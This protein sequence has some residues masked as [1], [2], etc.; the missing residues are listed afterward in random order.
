MAMSEAAIEAA[1]TE[2][3]IDGTIKT[4]G[5][6]SVDADADAS[7]SPPVPATATVATG[8]QNYVTRATADAKRERPSFIPWTRS[9]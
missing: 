5:E 9:R 8:F 2:L 4:V 1:M 6:S 3:H 7:S